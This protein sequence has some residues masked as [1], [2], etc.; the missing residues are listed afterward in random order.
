MAL[1]Q[2]TGATLLDR[3]SLDLLL[4]SVWHCTWWAGN[5]ELL[6]QG[7]CHSHPFLASPATICVCLVPHQ[8]WG[9]WGSGFSNWSAWKPTHTKVIIFHFISWLSWRSS[10]CSI[11]RCRVRRCRQVGGSAVGMHNSSPTYTRLYVIPN[12]HLSFFVSVFSESN[13]D[14]KPLKCYCTAA[15]QVL[16]EYQLAELRKCFRWPRYSTWD[17]PHTVHK[18]RMFTNSNPQLWI[19]YYHLSKIIK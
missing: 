15:M 3:S 16:E 6:A 18:I 4:R 17:F 8:C 2:G 12:S 1:G 19:M 13:T 11:A 7:E 14:C 10:S 5:H 9:H